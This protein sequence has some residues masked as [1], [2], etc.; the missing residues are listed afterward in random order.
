M[1]AQKYQLFHPVNILGIAQ[2]RAVRFVFVIFRG[3]YFISNIRTDLF[4]RISAIYLL[5]LVVVFR[6][7]LSRTSRIFIDHFLF[8]ALSYRPR[9]GP[10]YSITN[11]ARIDDLFDLDVRVP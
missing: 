5:T 4:G 8:D 2:T 7:A 1:F 11:C 9:S 6:T 3:K 10:R